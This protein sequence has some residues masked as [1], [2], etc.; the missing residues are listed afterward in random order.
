MQQFP[1]EKER[2][3]KRSTFSSSLF[4]SSFYTLEDSDKL[5]HL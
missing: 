5:S 1:L 2:K 4:N 3:K